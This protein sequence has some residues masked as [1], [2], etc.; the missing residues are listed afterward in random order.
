MPSRWLKLRPWYYT[1]ARRQ[2]TRAAEFQ[3]VLIEEDVSPLPVF[4]DEHDLAVIGMYE[5]DAE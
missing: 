4:F 2:P 1:A 5:D 3:R